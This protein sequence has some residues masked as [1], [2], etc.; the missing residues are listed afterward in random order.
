MEIVVIGGG[1]SGLGAGYRLCQKGYNVTILEKE[2]HTGGLAS[3]YSIGDDY[4]PKTYH[5]IMVEDT[6]TI[7]LVKELKLH[8]DFYWKRLKTG[9]LYKKTIY[10]FSSP[11]HI[12]RFKPLSVLDR[13][14]FGLM[15][16]ASRKK[17]DWMHLDN[18]NVKDWVCENYGIGVYENLVKHIVLDKFNESPEKISAAWLMSRFGHESR[19]VSG[20][21]G[22]IRNGGIQR[23]IDRLEEEIKKNRGEVKTQI[24]LKRVEVDQGRVKGVVYGED[25]EFVEANAVIST[26]PTPALLKT[27]A[28]FPKPYKERLEQIRY[29]ACICVTLGLKEKVSEYYWL[30]IVGNYPFVG[31]FE[32]RHLNITSSPMGVMYVVKYLDTTHPDWSRSGDYIVEHYLDRL[33]EIFPRL[34]E[35]ILWS[36]IF[37]TPYSTPVYSMNYGRYMP[38]IHSPIQ[39]LYI[40]GISRVYPNDRYMGTALKS[41]FE[42]AEVAMQDYENL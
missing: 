14:R 35:R 30:N 8:P 22:Y 20:R 41:G 36:R 19:S 38:S 12:M 23:I 21:F 40:T 3:S 42:A 13:I 9:F 6:T 7:S 25:D 39:G 32:H 27:V 18:V 29:K 2:D 5:H 37:K 16:W 15:V 24:N 28:D 10:N 31:L 34:K 1:L 11:L 26:I 17:M 4:I 33:E